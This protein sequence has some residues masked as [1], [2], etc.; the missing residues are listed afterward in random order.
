MFGLPLVAAAESVVTPTPAG[1]DAANDYNSLILSQPGLLHYFKLDETSGTIAYDS[2]S[3]AR[4]ADIYGG[5]G[6]NAPGALATE[7]AMTFNGTNSHVWTYPLGDMAYPLTMSAWIKPMSADGTIAR[8]WMDLQGGYLHSGLWAGA[9]VGTVNL[10]SARPVQLGV[11]HHV[12]LSASPSSA[13]LF[14]DGRRVGWVSAPPGLSFSLYW[15]LLTIGSGSMH[16]FTGDT[17]GGPWFNGSIDEVAIFGGS[18]S[19]ADLKTEVTTAGYPIG[20]GLSVDELRVANASSNVQYCECA[21]PVNPQVGNLTETA[22]DLAVAGRG[23]GLTWARSY[24][25]LVAGTQ[26]RLGYGWRDGYDMRINID[27][28]SGAA[29]VVQENG[30]PVTFATNGTAYEPLGRYFATLVH[31]GDGTWTFTRRSREIF[32]FDANRRLIAVTDRNNRSTILSYT[33][34]QLTTVTDAAGRTLTLAYTGAL[35]HTVTDTAGRVVT[36]DYDGSGNLWKVTDVGRGAAGA[37]RG[38]TT[39]GYDGSH[40]LTTVLDPRQAGSGSPVP[41][42]T[43]YDA[44]GRVDWQKD[45]LTRQ[46]SFAYTGNPASQTTVTSPKGNATVFNYDVNGLMTSVTRG[47]GTAQASTTS[48]E[49]DPITWGV[50][51]KTDGRGNVWQYSYKD[52]GGA[53]DPNGNVLK[54]TD[55]SVPPRVT[56]LSYDAAKNV[57]TSVQTPKFAGTGTKTTYTYDAAGNPLTVSAPLVETG[58]TAT[59]TYQHSDA[60][61]PE[62]ITGIQDPSGRT[63][64]LVHD[65]TTG[66]VT[67]ATDAGGNA[68]AYVVDASTGYVSALVPPNGTANSNALLL[69]YIFQFTYNGFGQTLTAAHAGFPGTVTNAYDLDGNLASATDRDG[70]LTTYVY[71]AANQLTVTHRPVPVT[72]PPTVS[73]LG[74]AYDLDGNVTTQTDAGNVSTDYTYDPLGRVATVV[75]PA[76]YG[77]PSRLPTSYAYDGNDNVT[78]VQEPGG[79]CAAVPKV[80]CTT[81]T[82]DPANELTSIDYSA[83]ATP[84]VTMTYD[85]DGHR[86]TQADG[87]TAT[88]TNVWDSL[89]RLTSSVDRNNQTVGYGYDLAGRTTSLVY[90]GSKTLARHFDT[91]GRLDYVRDWST[92]PKQTN[93]AYDPNSNLT[94][95]TYPNGVVST[96]TYDGDDHVI[97]MVTKK[98][99]TTLGEFAYTRS[100]DGVLNSMTP[101]NI[102]SAT[103]ETYTPYTPLDQVT[104]VNGTQKYYYDASDNLNGINGT[105]QGHNGNQ[106]WA[107]LSSGGYTT[108]TYDVRGNRTQK[109]PPSGA[110][111]SYSY[112]QANRLTAVSGTAAAS[113][114]YNGDGLRT[115]KVVGAT[116]TN[117]AWD[118]GG[119]LPMLL[120]EG[121]DTRYIYGPDGLPVEQMIGTT[122]SYLHHDQIG[123]TRL[124]TNDSTTTSPAGRY[125]FEAYGSQTYQSGTTTNL[126]Y[127]GQYTD[128]ETGFQYLRNR[129]YDPAI[130]EFLTRDPVA[131]LTRSDYGYAGG[132]PTNASDPSGLDYTYSRFE[133]MG[134]GEII[135][136]FNGDCDQIFATMRK[137][138]NEVQQKRENLVENFKQWSPLKPK[139]WAHVDRFDIARRVL[140]AFLLAADLNS[141]DD[142]RGYEWEKITDLINTPAPMMPERPTRRSRNRERGS[143]NWIE[144]PFNLPIPKWV[145]IDPILVP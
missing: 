98:S 57:V 10:F 37:N 45:Q 4:T 8:Y 90:P 40:R 41:V 84:D 93:F 17:I 44:L 91:A 21:D 30:A 48:F 122:V 102:T 118:Q 32:K 95:T 60:T 97:D 76:T 14:L 35:V 23:P 86:L 61:H 125:N 26:G 85:A 82:Y 144:A 116:T 138:A 9:P 141:C 78:A 53:Y 49:Y 7:P 136:Y 123:S 119:A 56:T 47:S 88:A 13:A 15:D 73:D 11:W 106:L 96:N 104:T 58:Q 83:A 124:I 18:L 99:S 92:T 112:D 131:A 34:S 135:D 145:P 24:D 140:S 33:G 134:A 72:T 66:Y 126:G 74:T 80:G 137:I 67:R 52:A 20:S 36:Y 117:F 107:T 114:Q 16:S 129:Y 100:N 110:A 101:T 111:S 22:T 1:A 50:S 31:N 25:S 121:A 64:T 71:D 113:Y 42:T 3:T 12:A 103:P 63:S 87:G 108:Y 68:T 132:E 39:F 142:F 75:P 81:N 62:D 89:G 115:R 70:H 54:V 105:V 69:A 5:V 28:T 77:N 139:L 29:T 43:H 109:A 51:K 55:P 27:A 143:R 46:T 79:N 133:G 120:Q 59:T 38:V 19:E 94:S 65:S 2:K 130:G 6:L 128:T 127:A